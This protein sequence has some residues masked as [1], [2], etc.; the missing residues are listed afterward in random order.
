MANWY[1]QCYSLQ[2]NSLVSETFSQDVVSQSLPLGG[3]FPS[4]FLP[5][6]EDCLHSGRSGLVKDL[7]DVS[8]GNL[9]G[10]GAT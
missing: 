5:V 1:R 4:L 9:E 7:L 3:G 6:T 2:L 10:L 8:F